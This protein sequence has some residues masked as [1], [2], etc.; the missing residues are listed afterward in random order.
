MK[1]PVKCSM[2][3]HSGG[4]D[5][6]PR[7][8]GMRL[9][10]IN[11]ALD[12]YSGVVCLI[13][14]CSLCFGRG[15]RERLR[16]CFQLMCAFNF[17][18]AIADITNWAF[19]GFA[20]PWYPAALWIGSLLYYLF[21]GPLLLAF[22]GYIA[23]YF[24]PRVQVWRGFV[25]IA[26]ALCAIQMAC[27]VLSLWNGMYFSVGAGNVYQRGSWFW[28][29]Q[30]VPMLIYLTDI[31]MMVRC[32][33]Y[34]RRKDFLSLSSYI[35]LPLAVEAVQMLNYG[36]AL[37]N[38]GVTLSILLIFANIH[39]EQ[40]LRIE[41]QETE[42]AEARID[43]MLSQIQPHFLY[44]S[45]TAIRHLCDT[46]QKQAKQAIRDFS[47]YLRG[48]MDSLKSRAPIPFEAELRHT[49]AYLHLEQQR[50]RDRLQVTCEIGPRDFTIPPLTLQPI[51]ENAV[52][53]GALG[54]ERGG[55][56][57]IR[58]EETE[59]AY[60]ITVW[61]DGLGFQLRPQAEGTGAHIGIANV[62]GRLASLCGG[63]LEIESAPGVGTT[64]TIII[65]KEESGR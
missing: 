41:H 5:P 45:L 4:P 50:Q 22:T 19:E 23:E 36:I 46:D 9:R 25:H 38:A 14:F 62:R 52:R 17:V 28:L 24:A 7:I 60:R 55:R 47:L 43:I 63:T 57:G 2:L 12:L 26:E 40:E 13:L 27:S 56:V 35:V 29:S 39:S 33:R 11:I 44:N 15:R 65:P 31:M 18:M 54:R 64:A 61:D 48:N 42:L 59:R 58:T 53:H 8:G 34:L 21:S 6:D 10:Q 3:N 51:V 37:L 20:R 49:E 1:S 30:A 32:R 16:R